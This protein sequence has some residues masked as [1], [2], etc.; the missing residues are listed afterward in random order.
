MKEGFRPGEK[1]REGN[2]SMANADFKIRDGVLTEYTGPGGEVII[3]SEVVGIAGQVFANRTDITAVRFNP[4]LRYM[5]WFAFEGCTALTEVRLPEGF[6][7]LGQ[8]AFSKCSALE[9]IRLPAS[10]AEFDAFNFDDDVGYGLFADCP[11][12]KS[13]EIDERNPRFSS[14]GCNV[15]LDKFD[16]KLLFGCGASTIPAE[17]KTVGERAF[18]R[19]PITDLFI[20]TGVVEIEE[21]AFLGCNLKTIT[22]DPKNEFFES[23]GNALV[24]KSDG[25]LLKGAQTTRIPDGVG[26]I[27]DLAFCGVKIKTITVPRSVYSV[28]FSAFAETPLEEV[29]LEEGVKVV[30]PKAFAGCKDL[31][32]AILPHSLLDNAGDEFAERGELLYA[33]GYGI[34]PDAFSGCGKVEVIFNGT[35]A[36]RR[37]LLKGTGLE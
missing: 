24:R 11:A 29:V 28:G 26:G 15:I 31:K 9:T 23:R 7:K 5:E 1:N 21:E 10:F 20:P 13:V 22:V 17:T 14:C 4:G 33:P 37:T 30:G 16:S 18:C 8:D 19:Q 3:P 6:V 27:S 12:V 34:A 25:R 2:A 36:E 35:P 32:K